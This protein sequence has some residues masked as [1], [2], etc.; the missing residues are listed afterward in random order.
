MINDK[1]CKVS[2]TRVVIHKWFR[3]SFTLSAVIS[4]HVEE[5]GTAQQLL[6]DAVSPGSS[7]IRTTEE[8][9]ELL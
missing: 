4:T 8:I 3:K 1:T 5:P 7:H 9:V 2:N 6:G